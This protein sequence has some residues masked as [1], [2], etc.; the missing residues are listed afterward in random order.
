MKTFTASVLA[1]ALASTSAAQDSWKSPDG[2]GNVKAEIGDT[3][4]DFGSTPPWVTLNAIMEQCSNLGCP[5]EGAVGYPTTIIRTP[6]GVDTVVQLHVSGSFNDPGEPGDKAHLVEIAR[7]VL[8]S[9][10]EMEASVIYQPGTCQ[11]TRDGCRYSEDP[12]FLDQYRASNAVIVRFESDQ[13]GQSS[14]INISFSLEEAAETDGICAGIMGI[15]G[16]VAATVSALAPVAGVGFAL[17]S[18]GCALG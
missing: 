7:S 4:I 1:L 14:D 15:A 11:Q 9:K 6:A 16:A 3:M 12:K 5:A 8:A 2:T 10:H 17:A 18:L 13:A